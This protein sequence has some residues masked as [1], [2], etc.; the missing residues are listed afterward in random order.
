MN[1]LLLGMGLAYAFLLTV[2]LFVLVKSRVHWLVKF[3]LVIVS[4]GFYILSYESWKQA[5]GW[6][7]A[8]NPPEQFLLH[9]A[10]VE[11]PDEELGS[12]GVIFIWVSDLESKQPASEPRAYQLDYD[13]DTHGKVEKALFKIQ[14]G[15]L[16]I[17]SFSSRQ[18]E[19]EKGEVKPLLG[20]K[21]EGLD[22]EDLPDPA[23][24]EK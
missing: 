16:Q 17:G 7:A 4:A 1:E 15:T 8:V 5:Q 18:K 3:A 10:V 19:V 14:N 9:Y 13:Q 11:E 24:P 23:L 22:F 6:P 2:L 12:D 21:Y 20:V